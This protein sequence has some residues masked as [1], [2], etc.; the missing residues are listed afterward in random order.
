[1]QKNIKLFVVIG[2]LVGILALVFFFMNRE[3]STKVVSFDGDAVITISED[4]YTPQNIKIKK[5]AKVTFVNNSGELRW[6][7]SD[8]HP[9]HLIFPE[10]DPRQ[11]VENGKSWEFKFEKEGTWGYHDHLAPYITGTIDVVN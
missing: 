9:S 3:D 5:G 8:L 2:V 7:A 4:T 6:P 1:M 10:F 11:P